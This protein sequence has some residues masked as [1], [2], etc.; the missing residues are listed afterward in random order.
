[1]MNSCTVAMCRPFLKHYF[2]TFI[3]CFSTK[4]NWRDLINGR[5]G[6]RWDSVFHY[7]GY[8]DISLSL[9]FFTLYHFGLCSCVRYDMFSVLAMFKYHKFNSCLD[10][11]H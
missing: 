11:S 2:I 6:F 10:F 3:I 7:S 4:I 8:V 5:F 9:V 1:M